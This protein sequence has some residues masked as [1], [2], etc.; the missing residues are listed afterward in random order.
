MAGLVCGECA[1]TVRQ[2]ALR[3]H[4]CGTLGPTLD[5]QTLILIAL[6]PVILLVMLVLNLLLL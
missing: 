5:F 2:R 3:C 1:A 4:V 6:A